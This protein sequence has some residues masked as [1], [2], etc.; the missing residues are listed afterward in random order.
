MSLITNATDTATSSDNEFITKNEVAKRL[1]VS[2]RTID[3]WRDRHI[4]RSHKIASQVRFLW[5]EVM[6]DIQSGKGAI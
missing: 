4:L 6:S 2:P 1:C 3:N 5:S